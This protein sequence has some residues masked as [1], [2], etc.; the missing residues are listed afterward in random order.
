MLFPRHGIS[1]K[2]YP[3]V[4]GSTTLMQDRAHQKAEETP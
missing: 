4:A 2:A 1:G 3:R